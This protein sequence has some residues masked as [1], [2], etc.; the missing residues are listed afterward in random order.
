[1]AVEHAVCFPFLCTVGHCGTQVDSIYVGSD[2]E[3]TA[4]GLASYVFELLKRIHVCR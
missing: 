2:D 1:M 3:V 4:F